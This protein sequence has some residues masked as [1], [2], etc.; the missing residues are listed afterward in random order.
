MINMIRKEGNLNLIDEDKIRP[1]LRDFEGRRQGEGE[2]QQFIPCPFCKGIYRKHTL[3]KH[4]KICLFNVNNEKCN[5]ASMGQNV[6]IVRGSNKTFFDKLRLKTE[7]FPKMRADKPSWIGKNDLVICQYAENYLPK[8]I[9]PRI[10]SAVSNRIRELGRLLIPLGDLYNIKTVLEVL[11]IEH[12]DKVVHAV[13]IIAGYNCTT[14]T[15]RASSLP[16]RIRNALLALCRA[17]KTLIVKQ[18]PVL[19][20]SNKEETLK[21]IKQFAMRV[22]GRWNID[23]KELAFKDL[24]KNA[25][26]CQSRVKS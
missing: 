2:L 16:Q 21:T 26:S 23:V 13:Q 14:K 1:V 5:V 11:N 20:I 12:Y 9:T 22:K 7:I 17:A 18:D 4:S 6:L 25:T 3:L 8:H 10:T 15:F 19:H 24:G